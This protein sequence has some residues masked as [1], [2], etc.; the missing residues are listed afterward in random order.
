MSASIPSKKS[1]ASPQSESPSGQAALLS[2]PGAEEQQQ[3]RDQYYNATIVERIDLTEDLAKFRIRPDEPLPPFEPGQYLAI[4][5]GNWE[6]RLSGTQEEELP[7]KKARKIVRRAYSISCP[8]LHADGTLATQDSVDYL[9][10]YITLVRHGENA[11]SKAPAL[12]PRLFGKNAGD[13]VVMERKVTGKYLLGSYDPDD[14]ML[15]LGTGTGEAPH[16]A[17]A[18]KLLATGH[19]GRIIIATSVRYRRDCAYR[20]EHEVLMQQY[21]NYVYLAL[22]TREEENIRTDHPNFVGKQY[23][24]ALFTSGRLAELAGDPLAPMNTHVFLCGNPAMIGYVPPGADAPE[25]PGML[26]LLR[27]AGFHDDV[28]EHHAGTVRFEKYW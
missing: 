14:T 5:L 1:P 11:A 4:G 6:K 3:L 20:N 28:Q 22:T 7:I 24:Q 25:N 23:L 9:E 18:A 10:F 12:T 21:D 13:R 2:P 15:F 26:P 17:M 19:R 16:N 8:L 27:A